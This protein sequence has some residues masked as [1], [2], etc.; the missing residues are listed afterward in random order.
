MAQTVL[1]VAPMPVS[2][3]NLATAVVASTVAKNLIE[4][5]AKTEFEKTVPTIYRRWTS[6]IHGHVA[7]SYAELTQEI[8]SGNV[9]FK[10]IAED[11]NGNIVCEDAEFSQLEH[12]LIQVKLSDNRWHNLTPYEMECGTAI[13][14]ISQWYLD[15]GD[16]LHAPNVDTI[17][18]GDVSLRGFL[19]NGGC[20]TGPIHVRFVTEVAPGVSLVLTDKGIWLA[21]SPITHEMYFSYERR[22]SYGRYFYDARLGVCA[23]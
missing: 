2:P 9:H 8:W 19:R 11:L 10:F 5:M 13:E 17:Y 7:K 1:P 23:I 21:S 22:Y 18:S 12:Q 20:L 6:I 16:F 3:S 14:T 4:G 15:D